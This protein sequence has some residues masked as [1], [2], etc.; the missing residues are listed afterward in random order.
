MAHQ[1]LISPGG[2][3]IQGSFGDHVD[4]IMVQKLPLRLTQGLL[5]AAIVMTIIVGLMILR[6]ALLRPANCIGFYTSV[7]AR[8][9]R[10]LESLEGS[11]MCTIDRIRQVF[12]HVPV[13]DGR[14]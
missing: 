13:P 6:Y 10:V 8:S 4:R 3:T 11:G 14:C 5:S 9:L 2:H 12:K 7:F 1:S